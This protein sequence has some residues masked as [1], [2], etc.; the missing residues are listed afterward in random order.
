MPL[1]EFYCPTCERCFEVRRSLKQG[2]DGVVCPECTGSNVQR[3]F[4]PIM[5]FSKGAGSTPTMI[6]GGGCS[7]CT[8]TNCSGCPSIRRG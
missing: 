8:I 7:G 3:I 6:G 1:Y 5:A 2:T 4:T